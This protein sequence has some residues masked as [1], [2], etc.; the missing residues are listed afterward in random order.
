MFDALVLG[1]HF[2]TSMSDEIFITSNKSSVEVRTV[3]L[4]FLPACQSHPMYR[5]GLGNVHCSI[6]I[7]HGAVIQGRLHIE[8]ERIP[9]FRVGKSS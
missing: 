4:I 2:E 5:E 6:C 7:T 1:R 9:T 3:F 8:D